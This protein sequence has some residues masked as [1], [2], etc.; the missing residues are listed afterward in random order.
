M[1]NPPENTAV[2]LV[3]R[4]VSFVPFA[5]EES[6]A[7][8]LSVR[9]VQNLIAPKT[10]K[11][12]SCPDEEALK[13]VMLCKARRLNP[14]EGDAYCIGFDTQDGPKF[15]LITAHQSFL[16]RAELHPEFDGME[17][18]V[19]VKEKDGKILE[20][21]GD[22]YTPD[23]TLVGG[24]AKVHFKNR[25]IPMFKK[26]ILAEFKKPFGVWQVTPGGMIVKCAEAD[27]LRSAFPT[28]MG[29]MYLREEI[30]ATVEVGPPIATPGRTLAKPR[31]K[32]LAAP[33]EPGFQ[34]TVIHRSEQISEPAPTPREEPKPAKKEKQAEPE[35]SRSP[36]PT[37]PQ[38]SEPE[39]PASTPPADV[40][41]P[42]ATEE[43]PKGRVIPIDNRED[44]MRIANAIRNFIDHEGVTMAE[45]ML[46][47]R[48]G[49]FAKPNQKDIGDLN[50]T[51][52][53]M[54]C[55]RWSDIAAEITMKRVG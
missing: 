47:L 6:D 43:A 17:S 5:A 14:W 46:W 26:L 10:K 8:K 23:Q 49:G 45:L 20:L 41:A 38:G 11:G 50:N 2:T 32:E 52:M 30:E 36:I 18:G 1:A 19:L 3:D 44:G 24:W 55:D 42:A 54:V 34:T 12:F 9:M 15:S 28:M 37:P 40:E 21:Q 7:I 53:L 22:F 39:P 27:A 25:K 16:K 13:F 48:E 33:T 29:G 31:T 4:E 35:A 51:K